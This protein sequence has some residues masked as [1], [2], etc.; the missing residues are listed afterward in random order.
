MKTDYYVE[1]SRKA[2]KILRGNLKIFKP[3]LTKYYGKQFYDK[4]A[5]ES[6]LKFQQ[7]LPEIPLHEGSRKHLFNLLMPHAAALIA[8]MKAMLENGKTAKEFGKVYYE[9]YYINYKKIPGFLLKLGKYIPRTFFFKKMISHV[10]RIMRESDDPETFDIQY[11]YTPKSEPYMIMKTSKCAMIHFIKKVNAEELLPLCNVFDFVQAK[12]M[13]IG[14]KQVSC[15]G[16]GD[17]ICEYHFFKK[18]DKVEFPGYLKGIIELK[19]P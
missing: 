3:V 11:I 12:T 2:F 19:I 9:S 1:N 13:G 7:L 4:I 17:G 8:I 16:Y 5:A 18:A 6:S 15:I 10:T 14:L